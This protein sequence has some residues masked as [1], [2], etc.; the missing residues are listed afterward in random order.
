M[1]KVLWQTDERSQN[2]FYRLQ[3]TDRRQGKTMNLN[4]DDFDFDEWQDLYQKDPV[5]FEAKRTQVL[6]AALAKAPSQMRP[7]LR[8]VLVDVELRAE[9]KDDRQRL[10]IA[11]KATSESMNE[12]AKG[13]QA[14]RQS[15]INP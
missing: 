4:T 2:Q 9:G 8:Q 3:T 11:M 15:V 6:E 13:L 7:R 14:L 10:E 5:A 1:R 12:L